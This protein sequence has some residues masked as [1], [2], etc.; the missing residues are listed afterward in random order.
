MKMKTLGIFVGFLGMAAISSAAVQNCPSSPPPNQAVTVVD[1]GVSAYTFSCGG[2]VFSNFSAQD[3]AGGQ[4]SGLTIYLHQATIDD[5]GVV[6]LNFNPLLD[7]VHPNVDDLYFYFQVSGSILELDLTNG[8]SGNTSIHE[9]GCSTAIDTIN[10]N[11]CTGGSANEL[12]ST[13]LVASGG[14]ATVFSGTF[15]VTN[16]VYIFKDIKV[17]SVSADGHMTSFSQSFHTA[18]PEPM[19]LSLMGVGLLGLGL[20]RKRIR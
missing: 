17:G 2:L 13:A 15:P 10:G 1:A 18:V 19:T 7:S 12:G 6:V 14:A 8:G 11:I 3:A 4:T 5:N 16:P 20:L 9:R